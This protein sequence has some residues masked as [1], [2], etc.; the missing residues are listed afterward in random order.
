MDLL[1]KFGKHEIK[2][3]LINWTLILSFTTIF[4]EQACGASG[5]IY[6]LIDIPIVAMLMTKAK[7][8]YRF[9]WNKTVMSITIVVLLS[10]LSAFVGA[11]INHSNIINTIYGFYK[12][13]RGFVFFYCVFALVNDASIE[14]S[15][16]LFKYIFNTNVVF[17]I[18]QLLVLHINQDNLGG[19]FG[20]IVGV[21]QYTNLFFVVISVYCIAKIML[22][23]IPKD[24]RRNNLLILIIMLGIA[25]AAEI[26]FF[27]VEII[28][29][30][31]IT[32]IFSRKKFRSTLI[33]AFIVI[34]VI[35]SYN[36][37]ISMF[38]KFANLVNEL[39]R[40]GI[41]RLIGLQRHYSSDIDIGRAVIFAFS[42]R[43]FLTNQQSRLFGLGI[44][45]ITSSSF[46][47][48]IFWRMNNITHYDQFSTSNIYIEQGII[49]F[50]LYVAFYMMMI[51]NAL[52]SLKKKRNTQYAS[53][54]IMAVLSSMLMF[55]YNNS[56]LSQLCFINYWFLAVILRKVGEKP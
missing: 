49:G 6:F 31:S 13:F 44:G 42:N 51:I 32:Y 52:H 25:A 9:V 41:N 11:V 16:K 2:I 27:F 46:V 47:N 1:F 54:L 38:P 5:L 36:L 45:N 10:F 40:G 19:F 4:L 48:N 20:I 39:R 8:I 35:L 12:F 17:T 7:T 21:N 53:M 23:D 15:K 28:I 30:L 29:L 14:R 50:A 55:V 26:K 56:L 24:E 37:L 3:D 22:F 34:I 18:F 43:H 33:F